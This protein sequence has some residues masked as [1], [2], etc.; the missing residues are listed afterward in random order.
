MFAKLEN[1]KD[2]I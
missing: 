2:Y 1:Q